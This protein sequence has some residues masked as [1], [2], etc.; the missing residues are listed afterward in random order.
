MLKLLH[1]LIKFNFYGTTERLLDVIHPLIRALDRRQVGVLRATHSLSMKEGL[2]NAD[3]K[4]EETS[5]LTTTSAD[6]KGKAYEVKEETKEEMKDDS[7]DLTNNMTDFEEEKSLVSYLEEKPW[8][9]VLLEFMES[10]MVML[11]VLVLVLAAVVVTIYQMFTDAPDTAGSPI[12]IWGIIV[13]V[14]FILEVGVRMYCHTWVRGSFLTF[15]GNPFN[16]IDLLVIG[17]DILFLCLPS[18]TNSSGKMAKIARLVRLVRLVRIL[19][20]AKVISALSNL[21]PVLTHSLT[22]SVTHLLTHL[23]AFA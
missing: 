9:E 21:E 15:I 17:I 6:S 16:M 3:K 7:L 12:F 10:I 1:K 2:A 20:A 18:N 13:L 14:I 11:L 8:Q 4:T 5:G 22:Y 19:K 23:L